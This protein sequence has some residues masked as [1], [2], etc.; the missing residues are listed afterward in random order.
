MSQPPNAT[1]K[2]GS[3]GSLR[4]TRQSSVDCADTTSNLI[5]EQFD[6]PCLSCGK[7]LTLDESDLCHECEREPAK[8]ITFG[9]V[10]ELASLGQRVAGN[11]SFFFPDFDL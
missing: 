1:D 8:Q 3:N 5:A 6:D 7:P 9:D 2:S 4:P 11:R 10:A